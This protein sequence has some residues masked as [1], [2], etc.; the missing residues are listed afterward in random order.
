MKKLQFPIMLFLLACM[1]TLYAYD[2]ITLYG[3]E[4]ST[5]DRYNSNGD[6]LTSVRDILRQD[7]ANYYVYNLIDRYDQPDGFF[8][9][10][11]NRDLFGTAQI[12]IQPALARQ[13]LGNEP[14]SISVFVLTPNLIDVEAGLPN[15]NAD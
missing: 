1:N 3:A 2:G 4:I 13:I 14:V 10:K 7:R 9:I 5:N 15:P 12:R 6:R 8:N 11:S